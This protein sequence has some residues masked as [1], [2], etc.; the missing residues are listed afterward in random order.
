MASIQAIAPSLM[1][2]APDRGCARRPSGTSWKL[3]LGVGLF[4]LVLL[5]DAVLIT[6]AVPGTDGL[7][8]LYPFTT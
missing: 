8:P 5:A 4:V 1:A 2:F 7:V 6:R 3:L